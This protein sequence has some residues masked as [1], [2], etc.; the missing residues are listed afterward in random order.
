MKHI[1]LV[2]RKLWQKEPCRLVFAVLLAA[3]IGIITGHTVI[4]A[5]SGSV[6]VVDGASMEPTYAPGAFVYTEPITTPLQ[7]GDIVLINDG[8]KEYALKRIVGLPGERVQFWRG[9]IFINRVMLR[10]HY[11]RPHTYTFPDEKVGLCHFELGQDEYLVLGDNRLWSVDSRRYGPIT[12][13][14]IKSRVP[15]PP[16]SMRVDFAAFTLPQLGKRTIR[17]M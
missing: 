14:Q 15:L 16:E 6:S 1:V 12:R 3:A 8:Q 11:L 4:A 9:Y 7:R 5:V 17:P 2:S 13:K 10:E